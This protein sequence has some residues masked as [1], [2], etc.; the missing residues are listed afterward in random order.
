MHDGK[1]GLGRQRLL[2]TA[3][4]REI[5][6]TGL[7]ALGDRDLSGRT[8]QDDLAGRIKPLPR[9]SV[10]DIIPSAG[11]DL[12]EDARRLGATSAGNHGNDV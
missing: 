9:Q 7:K 6:K 5:A 8:A 1:L 4:G 2:V 3:H 11:L 12:V 10:D